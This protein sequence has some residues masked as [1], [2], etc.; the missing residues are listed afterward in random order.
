MKVLALVIVMIFSV[1]CFSQDQGQTKNTVK[2]DPKELEKLDEDLKPKEDCDKKAKK[3]IE[4]KPESISLGSGTTG[5]SLEG[6]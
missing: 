3:E 5:C 4:I 2:I 1:S 6:I